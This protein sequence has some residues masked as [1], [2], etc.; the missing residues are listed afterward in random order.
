MAFIVFVKGFFD[1]LQYIILYEKIIRNRKIKA[2]RKVS[3]YNC[4]TQQLNHLGDKLFR[5]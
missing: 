2:K 5:G 3:Q 4:K 1:V